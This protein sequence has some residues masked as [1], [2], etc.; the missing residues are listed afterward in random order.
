MNNIYFKTVPAES[1]KVGDLMR[2]VEEDK[3][4]T[5]FYHFRAT[6]VFIGDLQIPVFG[7]DGIF[8]GN[9]VDKDVVEIEWTPIELTRSFKTKYYRTAPVEIATTAVEDT[10]Q[11]ITSTEHSEEI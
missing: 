11:L 2:Q 8:I 10:T 3:R 9:R 5:D 4:H 7:P 1:I 6:S